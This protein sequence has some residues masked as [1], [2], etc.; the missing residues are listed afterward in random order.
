LENSKVHKRGI[1][2]L[3]SQSMSQTQLI[4][5]PSIVALE[6][7]RQRTEMFDAYNPSFKKQETH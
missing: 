3:P 5:T 2:E 6:A 1:S 4:E 7:A